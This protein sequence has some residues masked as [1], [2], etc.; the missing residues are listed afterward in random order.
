MHYS[1]RGSVKFLFMEN[2]TVIAC[3]LLQFAQGL[4]SRVKHWKKWYVSHGSRHR[5]HS[6]QCVV[7][8][9]KGGRVTKALPG[10]GGDVGT[11]P[12][13][14]CDLMQVMSSPMVTLK[15]ID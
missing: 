10:H 15:K 4:K 1:L 12:N 14:L 7:P 8:G 11:G 2:E 9:E 5:N 3:S 13:C 6:Q